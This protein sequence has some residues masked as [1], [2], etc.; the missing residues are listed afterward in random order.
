MLFYIFQ[1]FIQES[2]MHRIT[3]VLYIPLTFSDCLLDYHY[4]SMFDPWTWPAPLPRNAA[5]A[6]P[7]ISR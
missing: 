6:V 3:D 2:I 1:I 5:A 7:A 4:T